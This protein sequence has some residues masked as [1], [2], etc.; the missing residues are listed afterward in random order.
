MIVK[1][2]KIFK[3][4]KF[5]L[6]QI[7]KPVIHNYHLE[8]F[9]GRVLLL[10]RDFIKL[11]FDLFLPRL[12]IWYHESKMSQR[13]SLTAFPKYFP[14]FR[15][16]PKHLS[17]IYLFSV[18]SSNTSY[19]DIHYFIDMLFFAFCQKDGEEIKDWLRNKVH[20][21]YCKIFLII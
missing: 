21:F 16:L 13:W 7:V 3:D 11:H 6:L 14:S 17:K 8:K 2:I 5:H 15:D 10:Q 4:V 18:L 1:P 19:F 12:G 9:L 20:Y